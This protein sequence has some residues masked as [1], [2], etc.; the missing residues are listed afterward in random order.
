MRRAYAVLA[1]VLWQQKSNFG[2][3]ES[4]HHIL[5]EQVLMILRLRAV[6]IPMKGYSSSRAQS[7]A[8]AP[9]LSRGGLFLHS[10]LQLTVVNKQAK[11]KNQEP[12][13]GYDP[14]VFDTLQGHLPDKNLP[15]CL[16]PQYGPRQSPTVLS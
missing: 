10:V 11:N 2:W 16:G 7:G 3:G 14:V 6:R 13:C 12:S 9:T 4:R 15:P 8:T 1:M 5:A